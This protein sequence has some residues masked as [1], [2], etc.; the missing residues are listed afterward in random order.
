MDDAGRV[1]AWNKAAEEMFGWSQ[2]EALKA[3]MG[4]LIVPPQ[5]R[6]RHARG[7]DHYNRT[8]E[9]PVLEQKVK[10]TALRRD[11]S[12]FPIELSIFPMD[13][14]DG[15]QSFYAFIRS[16]A[17]EEAALRAHELRA[18]E[19]EALLAVAQ[20]LLEDVS[21][22]EFTQFC[23]D[24]V[25]TVSGMEA[26]HFLVVRGRGI[27]SRLHPTGIWH[28]SDPRFQPVV[29]ATNSLRFSIGEGL[30]G[31]AWQSGELQALND[32]ANSCQFVRREIFAEVGFS[33]ATALPV[34]IGG[35]IQGVLEFFGTSKA[36]LDEEVLRMLQTVGKQIGVAIRR[37]EVA[38][39]RE[40]LRREMSHRVG[41]SLTVLA[42]IYRSCSRKAATKDELDE[43]FLGRL[44]AV[45]RANRMAVEAPSKGIALAALIH[46]AIS[47]LPQCETVP[48]K[49]LQMDI[50]SDC[51]MPLALI[52]NEL[53]TNALKH[54]GACEDNRITIK[55][56]RDDS[57]NHIVL[58]WHEAR[59]VPMRLPPPVGGRTGFGTKLLQAMVEG[60]LGGSFERK[61]DETSFRMVV[62]IP[63]DRV[64][65]YQ[66]ELVE[67]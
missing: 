58:E 63:R 31:R 36:R 46:D 65:F 4:E 61:L 39:Y 62:R 16:M 42:S 3:S 24:K 47:I 52:L 2:S 21:L 41:N 28:L 20:M 60:Q 14:A 11:R 38:E 40:T 49:A 30:P 26:G 51:V 22:E 18:R 33:R 66:D 6:D 55:A 53:A 54:G 25:C 5:H 43:V 17:A 9:G 8:G 48:I 37:K 64:E 29:D 15:T 35:K 12:E 57:R 32:L 19:G 34:R 45:G 27:L 50:Q 13:N 44:V 56:A 1:I 10:I 23:L 7:L 59:S 67:C